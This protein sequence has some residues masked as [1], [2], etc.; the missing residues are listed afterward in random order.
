MSYM[1]IILL[2]FFKFILL[3]LCHF[4]ILI[5]NRSGMSTTTAE[6]EGELGPVSPV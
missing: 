2:D 6:A 4:A 5:S 3:G 1:F